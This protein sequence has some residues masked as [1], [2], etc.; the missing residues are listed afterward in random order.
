MSYYD[1][2]PDYMDDE[3]D[4]DDEEEDDGF[5]PDFD[6]DEDLSDFAE[7]GGNSALRAATASNPRNLPCPSCDR[8]NMLTPKDRSLG[9]CCDRCA[10]EAERGGGY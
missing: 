5:E 1:D 4:Y 10:D 8:P 3:R 7:P 6:G 2:E 9:Y